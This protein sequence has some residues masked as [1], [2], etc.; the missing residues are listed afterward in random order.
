MNL[1]E[2]RDCRNDGRVNSAE[3]VLTMDDVRAWREDS[4]AQG[5]R[6]VL[7]NGCFD[8][9]HVGHLQSFRAGRALGDCLLVGVNSDR[10]V[11]QLKGPG[12]P[13]VPE[14]ERAT[15]IAGLRMVDAVTIFDDTSAVELVNHVRPDVYIKGADYQGSGPQVI[16]E[17][18]LPEADAVRRVGGVVILVPVVTGVS[19]TSLIERMAR[20]ADQ[21]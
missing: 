20:M 16:D 17:A 7:T 3:L 21:R 4:V 6:V 19:T 9:L 14:H 11:S 2:P 10:S 15:L 13:L 12:R 5:R 18:R 1:F 8:L